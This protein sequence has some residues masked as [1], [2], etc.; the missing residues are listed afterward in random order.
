MPSGEDTALDPQVKAAIA[1]AKARGDVPWETLSVDDARTAYIAANQATV[2]ATIA[3]QA[4]QDL[5]LDLPGRTIAARLYRPEA[6]ANPALIIFFHGGGFVLG[7]L[8]SHDNL[9]R[10]LCRDT[11]ALV[12]AIDYRLAPEHPCPAAADD[13]FDSV[14][15]AKDNG[16]TIGWGGDHL[17]L[18]G[19]SAGANLAA[20]T[21]I[22][23]RD[24]G[25]TS[26]SAQVLIYPV[27]DT[28]TDTPSY[29]RCAEGYRLTRSL[30]TWFLDHY[31]PEGM[32]RTTP[33]AAPLRTPDLSNLPPA[34]VIT[35]GFDPLGDEG[36]AYAERLKAEGC[37]VEHMH[38]PGM[39][40]GFC[41]MFGILDTGAT[42]MDRVARWLRT[43]LAKAGAWQWGKP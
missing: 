3:V 34:L 11:G 15:W 37:K 36:H 38:F 16:A 28:F 4:V 20:V 23:M 14:R 1:A 18:S 26:A 2:G 29:Q 42:A 33:I 35:A 30:M 39:I 21:A 27:A 12:L 32:D 8:E 6:G 10:R 31:L 40:H 17:A 13:A 24:T 41:N 43:H 9:C 7:N 25:E 19:D 5:R 22:R